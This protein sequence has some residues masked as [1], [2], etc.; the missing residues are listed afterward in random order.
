MIGALI[1]DIVG[2]R[3]EFTEFKGKK[4]DF[5]EEY[6]YNG[7]LYVTTTVGYGRMLN[8]YRS[9]DGKVVYK[10]GLKYMI[11]N[12]DF[13]KD[14]LFCEYAYIINLDTQCLEF[15][16]GFQK[17]PDEHNRYGAETCDNMGKYYPCKMVSYYPLDFDKSVEDVVADMNNIANE[18]EE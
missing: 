1:G 2:S 13:I 9:G 12:K 4:F 18:G 16:L 10:N 5:L 11:D 14:S 6:K 7:S 15:W 3:F 8:Y 17:E